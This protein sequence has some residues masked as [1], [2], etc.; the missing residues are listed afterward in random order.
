MIL[1]LV[2]PPSTRSSTTASTYGI[3]AGKAVS[4]TGSY[5][6]VVWVRDLD[7]GQVL[8]GPFANIPAVTKRARLRT[9]PGVPSVSSV[10]F[11]Q[12]RNGRPLIATACRDVVRIWDARSGRQL[13][14][15]EV[16]G[17]RIEAVALGASSDRDVLLAL[18]SPSGA[19]SV[20]DVERGERLTGITL[21]AGVT[22]LW[23]VHGE[24]TLVVLGTDGFLHVFDLVLT[25]E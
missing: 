1:R 25:P 9:K 6:G 10:S 19:V 7:N 14:A 15:Q 17:R 2:H 3:F 20:W 21:D 11:L 5:S 22:G 18:G 13:P 23:F 4:I 12:T 16:A 24:P 8:A